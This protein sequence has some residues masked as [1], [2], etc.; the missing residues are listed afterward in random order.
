M[1]TDSPSNRGRAFEVEVAD[2]FRALGARVELDRG[3]AGNQVDIVVTETTPA[4]ADVRTAVEC[5]AF[6]RPVGVGPVNAFAALW[7]L[8][9]TRNLVQRAA[10]VSASGYSRQAQDAAAEH[11]L[12]LLDISD[13]KARV[14]VRDPADIALNVVTVDE[15]RRD[16]TKVRLFAVMPFA[17][18][19]ED[20]YIYGIRDV[21][22]RLGLFVERADEVEHS[23]NIVELVQEK[24]RTS[25]AVVADTSVMN[26]NV[27][28]EIGYAHGVTTPTV[29]ACR[30]GAQM[31][32]DIQSVNHIRYKNINDLNRRLESRLR[33]MFKLGSDAG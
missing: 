12:D 5:K 20:L 29:L 4:G 19:F 31:P 3:L 21:A 11:G 1:S 25:D 14:A 16:A 8:F 15:G 26:P 23:G 10:M 30:D 9:R 17:S 22:E 32:F 33:S 24:I 18:E 28:Y 7:H 6:D 27:F 2:L 13:L